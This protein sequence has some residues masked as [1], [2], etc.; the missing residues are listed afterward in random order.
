MVRELCCSFL[1]SILDNCCTKNRR[2]GQRDRT[3][4]LAFE[5]FVRSRNSLRAG[6]SDV[7]VAVS[8]P[9]FAAAVVVAVVAVAAVVSDDAVVQ[10]WLSELPAELPGA[11]ESSASSAAG[12]PVLAHR[13]H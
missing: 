6:H 3:Y 12:A 7:A 11:L 13:S 10:H 2:F 1:G 8:A 4:S 5:D 9:V